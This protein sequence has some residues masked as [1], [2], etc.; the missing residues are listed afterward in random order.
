MIITMDMAQDYYCVKHNALPC[1]VILEL[2]GDT[3]H[4]DNCWLDE[5]GC[6]F[7]LRPTDRE[8]PTNVNDFEP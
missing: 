1:S 4:C 2:C 8:S 3:D 6:D 5:S 7:I